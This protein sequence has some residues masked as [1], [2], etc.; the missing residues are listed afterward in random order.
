MQA[1]KTT[2]DDLSIFAHDESQS[3]L[4]HLDF[5]RTV[6]GREWLKHLLGKPLATLKEITETQQLLQ[7]IISV[8]DKWPQQISN[9]T[10]MVLEK[11]YETGLQDIPNSPNAFS[12]FIYKIFNSADY[13]LT[14]YSVVHFD[15]FIRGMHVIEELLQHEDNP[16]LL[17]V[18]ID[19]IHHLLHKPELQKIL[20]LNKEKKLSTA[21]N[22]EQGYFF[23]RSFKHE[24]F[25]LIDLYNRLD[26]YYSM[27][28]ACINFQYQFP[29]FIEAAQP[30][31][32]ATQLY[33]PLLQTPVAYD[34]NLN[35]QQNFLFLTGA[36]MAGKSTFIKA[37]GVAAYLAHLGMA[38]PAA[39][40]QIT[41]MDG[42]L[43]NINVVDNIIKG[44]SY[45]FNEVQ[46][47][48]KT[49]EKISDGKKWLILI[50][51]LF[52]GTN[53]IDAMKC[54]STVIEGLLKI[55]NSVF[56]LSTHLYEIGESLKP[57]PN[58][59]FRYFETDVKDDQL[60]FS[61]QLKEGV[62][63]DRLGYLILKKEGVVELL[64]KL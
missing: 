54:S 6:G 49:I 18:I 39:Q 36:N 55:H 33:H 63:N 9:G 51:E 41:C 11:F 37:V 3:L 32:H 28:T 43:S 62:S 29:D 16:P 1:D 15:E 50:D 26:A 40:M 48:R 5:T 38:V 57:F 23:R 45:F 4:H 7:R 44:E 24:C 2:L 22:L 30:L 47:V 13:S 60:I 19:R 64:E 20:Q 31:M 17:Q 46:R 27:A 42:L 61:Y 35:P 34:I 10:I 21:E 8:H 14:K 12:S 56:I 58:I 25:D 52:K 53:M 59:Q